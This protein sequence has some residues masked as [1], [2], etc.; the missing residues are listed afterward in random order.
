[1]RGRKYGEPPI[2]EEGFSRGGRKRRKSGGLVASGTLSEKRLDS[3]P[4]KSKDD[5]VNGRVLPPPIGDRGAPLPVPLRSTRPSSPP[6]VDEGAP[7]FKS[8]GHIT[9]EGRRALPSS[10]FGLPGHGTGPEGKGPGSYPLDTPGRA[11]SALS[12]ASANATPAEESK[13]RARVHQKY[14]SLGEG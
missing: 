6:S 13:I 11:R 5:A 8:G 12:R 14:P 7:Q 4:R 10:D 9:A 1:M 3:R 2:E